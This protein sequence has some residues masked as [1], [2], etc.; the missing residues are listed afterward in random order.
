MGTVAEVMAEAVMVAV[1]VVAR[2]AL[3]AMMVEAR[4]VEIMVE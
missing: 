3:V 4:A 2:V 1:M